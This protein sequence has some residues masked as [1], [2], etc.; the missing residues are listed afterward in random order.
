MHTELKRNTFKNQ[1]FIVIYKDLLSP[2]LPVTACLVLG[3]MVEMMQMGGL[4]ITALMFKNQLK[5][6]ALIQDAFDMNRTVDGFG[7]GLD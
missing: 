3:I 7:I 4:P 1:S 6:T 5:T 2:L